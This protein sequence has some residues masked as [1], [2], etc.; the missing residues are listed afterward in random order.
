MKKHLLVFLTFFAT[1]VIISWPLVLNLTTAIVDPIDGL[2]LTWIMNWNIHTFI[3]GPIAWFN[4][5]NTNIFYPYLH[6]LAFSDYHLPGSIIALPF[7]VLFEEPLLA[8]NINFLLGF[9]LTGFS[10]YLLVLH[11]TKNN[12]AAF[13]AGFVGTFSTLHLN[14]APHL[15]LLNIWPVILAVL[16]LVKQRYWWFIFFFVASVTTTPL[17]LYFLLLIAIVFLV[18]EKANRARVAKSFFIS[19]AVSSLFL[20][21][22]W[23]VSREFHYT[24][25]ITDAINF[26]L[27]WT[28]LFTV[29]S[30]SKFSVLVPVIPDTTPGFLG[31]GMT[32]IIGAFIV[33]RF[34]FKEKLDWANEKIIK[35]FTVV[36]IIAFVLSFGPA[37][38]I[39][40]N[41]IHVGPLPGIPMPYLVF[42]YLI[43]GFAGFRT[44]SRWLIL[45]GFSFLLASIIYF[46]KRITPAWVIVFCL[47]TFWEIKTPMT[48]FAVPSRQEFP[49]EQAWLVK[50]QIGE[51]MIQFPINA[52]FDQPGVRLETLK[53]YY[54]TIHWHPMFNG[55]S[56][57]SPSEWENR[58]KY[59][60]NEF[61]S[62]NSLSLL[63]KLRIKL[64]L[65][66]KTWAAR[67]TE[68]PEVKLLK[69]FPNTVIYKLD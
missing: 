48:F 19:L 6:T 61:P 33:R 5:T 24:R 68:F 18:S 27:K 2:L 17:Y 4:F 62:K 56:G 16:F 13:L 34:I 63:K 49:A 60:Q 36:G 32:L 31:A 9:V 67:M 50:N 10:L 21:P 58:V 54:S 69:E 11:F 51:P 30:A 20:L 35:I 25:P 46:S 55:Y 66:P 23:L 52:W 29:S 39:F 45:A 3:S 14:Y 40:R 37:F 15:Q 8:F 26:S 65:T 64:I 57:F 41:T 53:M 38:H 44:A 43:P 59:L 28:D 1:A 12:H 42:Y 7:V 47:I 22:F